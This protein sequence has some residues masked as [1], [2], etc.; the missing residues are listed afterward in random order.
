MLDDIIGTLLWDV[1]LS[2]A[3]ELIGAVLSWLWRVYARALNVPILVGVLLDCAAGTAEGIRLGQGTPWQAVLG[4]VL[5]LGCPTLAVASTIALAN[6][7]QRE[8]RGVDDAPP[9]PLP[10]RAIAPGLPTVQLRTVDLR[11]AVD[12]SPAPAPDP[13]AARPYQAWGWGSRV[14][15][16]SVRRVRGSAE[17]E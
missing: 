3:G 9:E 1:I 7:L 14:E 8:H 2:G 5:I 13:A 15:V 11:K 17:A 6:R 16:A 4:T 10:R 12:S